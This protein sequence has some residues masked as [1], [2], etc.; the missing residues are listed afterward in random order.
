M[1]RGNPSECD[2]DYKGLSFYQKIKKT[3]GDEWDNELCAEHDGTIASFDKLSVKLDDLEDYKILCERKKYNLKKA[4]KL[5][6]F[7]VGTVAVI[8]PTAIISAPG[9][10]ASLGAAHL[11]GTASTGTAISALHGAALANASLAKFGLGA[12]AAGGFGTAGGVIVISAAGAAMT[13]IQSGIIINNYIGN[14]QDFKI[15][16]VNEG[17]GPAL[18]FINGFLSEK[19]QD[20]KDW[21]DA[22]R[23]LFVNNPWYFTTWE[24]STL[25]ELYKLLTGQTINVMKHLL[26]SEKTFNPLGW[27]SFIM[28]LIKNPW[29]T[30]M[31]KAMVTGSLIAALMART[32]NKDGFILMGNSLGTRVIYYA[33]EAL[34]TQEINCVK[35]VYL[36]GGTIDGADIE[37]WEKAARAVDGNIYNCYSSNDTVL[38]YLCQPANLF[39]TKPIGLG[40]IEYQDIK[41]KNIDVSDLVSSHM[42]Y[43]DKFGEILDIIHGTS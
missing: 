28:N 9:I 26:P 38:K 40:P 17:R 14:I 8:V 16:K 3:V 2:L 30:A 1:T 32:N 39:L 15:Q 12:L 19:T 20:S 36:L 27:A 21:R 37:G 42:E 31:V 25:T 23:K 43:K 33:L 41:I 4:V 7:M 10:A 29:L 18:I 13:S 11:L 35:D 22:V 24:A 34:S 6:G 5:T